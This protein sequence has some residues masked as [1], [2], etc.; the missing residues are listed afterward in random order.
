MYQT[1]RLGS[2]IISVNIQFYNCFL[3][4]NSKINTVA[5]RNIDIIR[6]NNPKLMTLILLHRPS[7]FHM[8]ILLGGQNILVCDSQ[9]VDYIYIYALTNVKYFHLS[10]K[11]KLVYWI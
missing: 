10:R 1:V 9:S 7:Y 11:V 6:L 8:H 4:G 5:I 2:E 3:I